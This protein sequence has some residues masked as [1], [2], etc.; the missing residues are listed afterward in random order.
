MSC[1]QKSPPPLTNL[2]LNELENSTDHRAKASI[3]KE[4]EFSRFVDSLYEDRDLLI[5]QIKEET[6]KRCQEKGAYTLPGELLA[7]Q[8]KQILSE[9]KE[10]ASESEM[11]T[12]QQLVCKVLAQIIVSVWIKKGVLKYK[13]KYNTSGPI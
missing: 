12:R 2:L 1:I 11:V 3:M 6:Y 8:L 7:D 4:L 5:E 13:H 10:Y 9:N